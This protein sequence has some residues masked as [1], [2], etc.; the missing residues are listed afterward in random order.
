MNKDI[1]KYGKNVV[2]GLTFR[3]LICGILGC[4]VAVFID[5]KL[6]NVVSA[7]ILSWICILCAL[8]F[9]IIGFVKYNGMPFERVILAFIKFQFLNPKKYTFKAK[10]LYEEMLKEDIDQKLKAN[11]TKKKERR[12][13]KNEFNSKDFEKGN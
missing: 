3:Q 4:V 8:P 1:N 13:K 7:E 11:I 10:N 9:A 12:K 6:K 5:L 2:F